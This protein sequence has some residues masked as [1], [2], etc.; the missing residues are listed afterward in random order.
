MDVWNSSRRF[1]SNMTGLFFF[2]LVCLFVL[3]RGVA[4]TQEVTDNLTDVVSRQHAES[5]IVRAITG[6][7]VQRL[8]SRRA[9]G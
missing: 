9:K 5:A 4:S 1:V 2:V 3:Q 7:R 6:V 8:P